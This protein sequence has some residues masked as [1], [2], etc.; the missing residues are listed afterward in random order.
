M[1]VKRYLSSLS[2]K[3]FFA[4]PVFVL[5]LI[6]W[7]AVA[8]LAADTQ[9]GFVRSFGGGDF[10]TNQDAS[11]YEIPEDGQYKI[12]PRSQN[13]LVSTQFALPEEAWGY[14]EWIVTANVNLSVAGAGVGLWND[15]GG[16]AL[17]LFPDGSGF[18]RYY[19][20]KDVSWSADVNVANYA[21]PARVSL[22]RDAN[23]TMLGRV[24]DVIVAARVLPFDM[25]DNA[26]PLVKTV[27]FVTQAPAPPDNRKTAKTSDSAQGAQA[28]YDGLDV[29]AWGLRPSASVFDAPDAP[30]EP[31]VE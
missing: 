28:I 24:N 31:D 7:G 17:L 23:G 30:N 2:K 26:P 29:Q 9:G 10:K 1:L 3:N 16:Y 27:S 19:E 15:G 22:T 6:F 18:M 12:T 25:K 21:C 5:S 11:K 20:G 4:V 14:R 8:A 13:S